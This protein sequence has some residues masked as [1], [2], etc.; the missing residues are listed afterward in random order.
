MGQCVLFEE[1]CASSGLGGGEQA[2]GCGVFQWTEDYL[3]VS[4]VC[5]LVRVYW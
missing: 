1:V 2:G 4:V 3:Q 5:A